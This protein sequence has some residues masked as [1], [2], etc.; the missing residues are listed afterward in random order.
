MSR[1]KRRIPEQAA[2]KGEYFIEQLKDN[3]RP[4]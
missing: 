2:E 3:R 1:S 4:P